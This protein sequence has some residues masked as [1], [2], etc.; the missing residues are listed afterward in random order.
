M[1]ALPEPLSAS[2]TSGPCMLIALSMR[3][4]YAVIVEADGTLRAVGFSDVNIDWRY[5]WRNGAWVDVGPYEGSDGYGTAEAP[6]DG[7]EE[8]SGRV[9]D[10]DRA[11]GSDQGDREDGTSRGLDPGEAS[12][13]EG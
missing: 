9:P 10:P 6:D 1:I 13:G 7:G 4:Q 5:D 2:S 8:V 12:G 11:D 3:P